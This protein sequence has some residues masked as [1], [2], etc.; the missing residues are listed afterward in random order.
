MTTKRTRWHFAVLGLSTTLLLAGG[1]R[2]DTFAVTY[3]I[4]VNTSS[5][6]G[7]DGYLDFQ[8]NPGGGATWDPAIATL[9]DFESD[10][11]LTGQFMPPELGD[12]SGALPGTV[13][14]DTDDVSASVNEDTEGITFGSY[15]NIFVTLDV[16]VVSRAADT[17]NSFFMNVFDTGFNPLFNDPALP[18]LV[19]IDL[20]AA[21]GAPAIANNSDGD[22]AIVSPITTPEPAS[23]LFAVTG[24]AGML[25]GC[26]I[27]RKSKVS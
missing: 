8:F 18:A 27:R 22:Q 17:G 12:V 6:E 4:S 20:D 16:P 13:T 23:L 9:F 26:R 21:T 24:L 11:N 2:A 25:A 1:A 10:G 3:E 7:T 15:F 19:E 5:V 14:I